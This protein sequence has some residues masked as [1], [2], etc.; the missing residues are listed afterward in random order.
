MGDKPPAGLVERKAAVGIEQVGPVAV[1][2]V[3]D[4]IEPF[5]FPTLGHVVQPALG[6]LVAGMI[7]VGKSRVGA[8]VRHAGQRAR[9]V[10]PLGDAVPVVTR[11]QMLG[12]PEAQAIPVGG[13]FPFPDDVTLRTQVDGVPLV[14]LG[15]PTIEVVMVLGDD[16]EIF[17]AGLLVTRHQPV[18]IPPLSFPKRDDVLV[19]ELRR[20]AVVREVIL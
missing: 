17:R 7:Q 15:I 6:V 8:V 20:V 3:L 2:Q 13:L 5:L 12:D 14:E 11:P 18:G 4:A 19:A 16:A 1:H 10:G 9:F